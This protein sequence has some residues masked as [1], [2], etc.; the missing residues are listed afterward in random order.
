MIR[1]TSRNLRSLNGS[2]CPASPD[3]AGGCTRV[4]RWA[5]AAVAFA[6]FARANPARLFVEFARLRTGVADAL[7]MARRRR[8]TSAEVFI[9]GSVLLGGAIGLLHHAAHPGTTTPNRCPDPQQAAACIG[10]AKGTAINHMLIPG[11]VGA[12]L[13]LI[14][15][16]AVLLLGRWTLAQIRPAV[17]RQR[18]PTAAAPAT[19]AAQFALPAAAPVPVRRSLTERTRHEVWR[20]DR[21]RCVDCE[22]RE[23][24][25][26]DHIIP[27]RRG[28]SN[29]TRN[30]ELRCDVCNGRKGAR[31]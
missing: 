7:T 29:T 15:A 21:R 18:R 19:L 13:G 2:S 1:P 5:T 20:R 31:I 8:Q 24:L 6:D 16:I 10:Q 11:L 12:G 22:S 4:A 30:I 23:N 14:C 28:G 3:L 25:E 27:V 9:E 17:Q 26:F